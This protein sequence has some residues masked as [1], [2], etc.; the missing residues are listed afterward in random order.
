MMT[1]I[2]SILNLKS[3]I[4]KILNYIICKSNRIPNTCL[5]HHNS[6]IK[7]TKFEG[8]NKI[9]SGVT[10]INCY[11][12]YGSYAGANTQM[13]NVV[14]GKYTSIAQN[15]KVLTGQHPTRDFVSTHQ[16]FY[17]TA[18]ISLLHY[19][20]K[21]LFQEY[22]FVPVPPPPPKSSEHS[23]WS[24]IIGN[25]V[26]ISSDVRIVQGIEIGDG[27]II[28]AGSVVTKKIP[29]YAI[30]GGIPA[31]IIRY[32]FSVDEIN[33]LRKLKWWNKPEKW[34]IEHAPYFA[35]VKCLQKVCKDEIIELF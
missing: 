32:R 26:W 12:G 1:D 10:A 14:I 2:M 19:V 17:S 33:F 23:G 18:G 6:N 24:A 34:I 25:D 35:D 20:N 7:G 11:F 5:I 13:S 30:V 22:K 4:K 31:K 8:S 29:D 28:A 9:S 21:Q 27:A 16:A 3:I 15:V